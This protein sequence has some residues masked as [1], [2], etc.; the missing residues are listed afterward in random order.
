[1]EPADSTSASVCVPAVNTGCACCPH[2]SH[3]P[4][5]LNITL[6][7]AHSAVRPSGQYQFGRQLLGDTRSWSI[8]IWAFDRLCP[9]SVPPSAP[10]VRLS[11]PSLRP[12]ST[13]AAPLTSPFP[14]TASPAAPHM[15]PC[16]PPRPAHLKGSTA[17]SQIPCPLTTSPVP[18]KASHAPLMPHSCPLIHSHVLLTLSPGSKTILPPSCPLPP[19]LSPHS[20]LHSSPSLPPSPHSAH[21]VWGESGQVARPCHTVRQGPIHAGQ[22]QVSLPPSPSAR[23]PH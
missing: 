15:L 23:H 21:L 10:A 2:L 7:D 5:S 20:S 22:L 8:L 12:S 1:M 14:L 19:S 9:P 6:G 3:T 4:A 11:P 16:A 17:P 18:L 13:T